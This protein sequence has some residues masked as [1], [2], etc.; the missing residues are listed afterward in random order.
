MDKDEI[1]AL[2][3]FFKSTNDNADEIILEF[4]KKCVYRFNRELPTSLKKKLD[5]DFLWAPSKIHDYRFDNINFW[6]FFVFLVFVFDKGYVNEIFTENNSYYYT[7]NSLSDVLDYMK[8]NSI[9]ELI[10][11]LLFS[12]EKHKT[13]IN[14]EIKEFFNKKKY[15]PLIC[16]QFISYRKQSSFF[17]MQDFKLQLKKEY[18][19]FHQMINNYFQNKNKSDE[20][21]NQIKI[22]EDLVNLMNQ[23]DKEF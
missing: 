20:S 19:E 15:I 21:N 1:K 16:V 14:D 2:T 6:Y 3:E 18:K 5:D 8:N 12:Y 17:T 11:K 13:L 22:S 23:I 4:I 9:I 10:G 7:E